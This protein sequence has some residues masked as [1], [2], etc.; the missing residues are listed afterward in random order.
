MHF[1]AKSGSLDAV[2]YLY[3]LG[4]SIN[5]IDRWGATPLSYATPFPNITSFLNSSGAILGS[6]QGDYLSLSSVY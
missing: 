1:A 4:L 2:K 3:S 6:P 5:P